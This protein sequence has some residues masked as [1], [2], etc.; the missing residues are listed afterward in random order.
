MKHEPYAGVIS[1]NNKWLDGILKKGTECH[2]GKTSVAW[3]M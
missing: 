1:A 2:I 3:M